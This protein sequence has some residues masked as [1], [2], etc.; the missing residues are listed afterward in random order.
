[1]AM[2]LKR[3]TAPG[4]RS[5]LNSLKVN[6]LKDLPDNQKFD[7]LTYETLEDIIEQVEENRE[8][9][10]GFCGVPTYSTLQYV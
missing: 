9:A 2:F 7:S 10:G 4:P 8:D 5:S 1:M 6:P 3:V